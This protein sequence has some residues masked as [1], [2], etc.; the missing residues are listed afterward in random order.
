MDLTVR[1]FR[2]DAQIGVVRVKPIPRRHAAL[3]GESTRM[4]LGALRDAPEL[5]TTRQIVR[6]IMEQRGMNTADLGMAETMRLR[7]ATSLRMLH[8]G[9]VTAEGEGRLGAP[10]LWELVE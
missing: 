7:T 4:I 5:L 6:R 10:R 8:S 1:L 9:K 2:P 3:H